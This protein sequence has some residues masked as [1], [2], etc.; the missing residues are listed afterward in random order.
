MLQL[1]TTN[2]PFSLKLLF[3]DIFLLFTLIINSFDMGII[4]PNSSELFFCAKELLLLVKINK[5]KPKLIS[6]ETHNVDCS[7]SEN[8]ESIKDFLIKNDFN[9]FKRTGPTTLF[10]RKN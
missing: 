9:I 2:K 7:E 5:L 10:N 4:E 8:L 1:K 6:I 3:N